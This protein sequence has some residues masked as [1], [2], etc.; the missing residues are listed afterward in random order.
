M[1]EICMCSK[2]VCFSFS[3]FSNVSPHCGLG[4]WLSLEGDWN[5]YQPGEQHW[6]EAACPII[7]GKRAK[8]FQ[9]EGRTLRNFLGRSMKGSSL[10]GPSS[11]HSCPVKKT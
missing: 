3:F 8:R 6:W 11:P 7:G 4:L 5:C 1:G 9:D 2:E 10:L